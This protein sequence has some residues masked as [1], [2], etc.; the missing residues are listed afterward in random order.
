MQSLPGCPAVVIC[1]HSL[2]DVQ[3]ACMSHGVPARAMPSE[4][5]VHWAPAQHVLQE[6]AGPAHAPANMAPARVHE[7]C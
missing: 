5:T 3:A 2:A 7:G 1:Q 4:W 6:P